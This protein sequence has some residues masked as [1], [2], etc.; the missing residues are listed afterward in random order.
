MEKLVLRPKELSVQP[1][2]PEARHIFNFLLR[3][4]EDFIASLRDYRKE[5]E[6]DINKKRIIISCLSPDVFPCVEEA[7]DYERIVETLQSV[8]IK[9]KNNVY[10]RHLLVSRRQAPTESISEFLQTLRGLTKECSF[11]DVSAAVSR[12]DLTRDSF[13]NNLSSLSVRQRLLEK[14]NLI[15]VQAYELADSL[16]RAQRQSQHMNQA[17]MTAASMTPLE[18][19]PDD[20]D[21]ALDGL[22]A[23]TARALSSSP[24]NKEVVHQP[25]CYCGLNQHSRLLC[26]AREAICHACKNRGHYSRVCRTKSSKQSMN[27]SSAAAV[28]SETRPVLASAPPSLQSA[29]IKG[30]PEGSPVEIL[31][32]SG[33]SENFIDAKVARRLNLAVKTESVSIGMA[34]SEVSVH[35]IGKVTGVL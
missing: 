4:V 10:A 7:V 24:R 14:D 16:D 25:C 27:K 1:E 12:E 35:T 31:V 8:Y 22:S 13:I 26:P 17:T 19:P 9:K 3:T 21:V 34:S 23:A 11:D 33:A 5:G 32:Y 15:L 6:P 30:S 2:A 28:F 29:V 18:G 20:C